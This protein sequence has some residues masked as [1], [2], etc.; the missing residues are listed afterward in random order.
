MQ[1]LA[2]EGCN[3]SPRSLQFE[4]LC[5]P[6]GWERQKMKKRERVKLQFVGPIIVYLCSQPL[7]RLCTSHIFLFTLG[8]HLASTQR[9]VTSA[10]A[11][12][13]PT[14]QCIHNGRNSFLVC[15]TSEPKIIN[16][17]FHM[18]IMRTK[19]GS[20]QERYPETE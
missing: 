15:V 13:S 7:Q 1:K 3:F 17:A 6:G 5:M 14:H 16:L 8:V 18:S 20:G 11:V 2:K 9:S 4:A 10:G 19:C 12:V